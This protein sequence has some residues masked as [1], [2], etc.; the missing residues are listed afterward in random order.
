LKIGYK[1]EEK[2]GF[3][4]N[5]GGKIAVTEW[6]SKVCCDAVILRKMSGIH[7]KVCGSTRL[8]SSPQWTRELVL[9]TP[10]SGFDLHHFISG[11]MAVY[12]AIKPDHQLF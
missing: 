3:L 5:L 8:P 1:K 6:L 10:P 2:I 12:P 9:G 4:G 7:F 11:L